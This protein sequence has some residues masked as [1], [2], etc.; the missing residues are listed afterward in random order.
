MGLSAALMSGI[1]Y[2]GVP[3]YSFR[4]NIVPAATLFAAPLAFTIV[5]RAILPFLFKLEVVTAYEY[6]ER[7]FGPSIRLLTSLLF[8]T[9]RMLWLTLV[10][11]GPT[12]ALKTI[13]PI[14]L[15]ATLETAFRSIHVDPAIGF[16]VLAIGVVGT[17]FTMLGGMR[18]VMWTDSLQ[19]VVL[20]AGLVGIVWLALDRD[21]LSFAA[22]WEVA[23]QDGHTRLF[24]FRFDWKEGTFWAAITGGLF[25]YLA[26]FGADQLAVQRYLAAK[27]IKSAQ[28]SAL[29]T[30]VVSIPITIILFVVGLVLFAFYKF[31]PVRI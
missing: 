6:L 10:T 30:L 11:F 8:L 4:V 19:F 29:L 17:I 22:A 21:G 16:W 28:E 15:P 20:M 14:R 24:D 13:L 1:S 31:T 3:S 26:D 5:S 23:R 7:R 9:S 27:S 12:V 18:A 2:L 25:L